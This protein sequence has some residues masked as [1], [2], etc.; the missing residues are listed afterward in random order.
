MENLLN[1]HSTLHYFKQANGLCTV[2]ANSVTG[3]ELERRLLRIQKTEVTPSTVKTVASECGLS[4]AEIEDLIEGKV[5][6][7][8]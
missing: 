4:Y 6:D 7:L 2:N 5:Y 8:W 1:S 3:Y